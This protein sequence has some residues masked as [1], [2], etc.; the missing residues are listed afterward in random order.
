MQDVPAVNLAALGVDISD[1]GILKLDIEGAELHLFKED[2]MA[3]SE[4]PHIF[5]ELHDRIVSGCSDAFSLFQVTVLW[6][7]IKGENIYRYVRLV[8]LFWYFPSLKSS[9]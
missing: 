9:L 3:L 4:I 7:R 8:D 6:L 1:I 5:V 2:E